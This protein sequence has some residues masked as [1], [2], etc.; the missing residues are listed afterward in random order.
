MR[1]A[2]GL[3]DPPAERRHRRG[4][5]VRPEAANTP[6]LSRHGT[7]ES[8]VVYIAQPLDRPDDLPG[9]T[10]KIKWLGSDHAIYITIN[11]IVQDG[12]R[13]PFEIFINSKNMEHHAWTVALN[14]DDLGGVPPRRRRSRSWSR[15]LKA[16]F[17]PRG[18]QWMEGRYVRRCWRRSAASSTP[19][20][21]RVRLAPTVSSGRWAEDRRAAPAAGGDPATSPGDPAAATGAAAPVELRRS[22]SRI[23]SGFATPA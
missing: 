5:E 22:R 16:V 18:G 12:R 11:D 9:R 10:Y 17:D 8:G 6:R 7:R 14:A 4:A 1:W 3:H 20:D 2:A 15:K 19:S 21:H 23:R 13:R